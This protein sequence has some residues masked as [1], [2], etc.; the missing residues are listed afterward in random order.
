VRVF[1]I[2]SDGQGLIWC[3]QIQD[4]HIVKGDEGPI[5]R[6]IDTFSQKIGRHQIS[7][8]RETQQLLINTTDQRIW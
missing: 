5:A 7:S 8:D 3:F 4:E 6:F 2:G 1:T